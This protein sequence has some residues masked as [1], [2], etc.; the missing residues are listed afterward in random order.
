MERRLPSDPELDRFPADIGG[1]SRG[2]STG[3]PSYSEIL[4]AFSEPPPSYQQAILSRVP[5]EN[6][7]QVR[8]VAWVRASGDYI[9]NRTNDSPQIT[10]L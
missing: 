4:T 5:D 6:V 8:T 1:D 9:S 2:D 3:P 7:S 10:G